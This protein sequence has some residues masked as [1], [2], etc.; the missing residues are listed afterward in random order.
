MSCLNV[1][2]IYFTRTCVTVAKHCLEV[3]SVDVLC[4]LMSSKLQLVM[5]PE[6]RG[7]SLVL[8][9]EEKPLGWPRSEME[10]GHLSGQQNWRRQRVYGG[11]D[12]VYGSFT[13]VL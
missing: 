1:I 12:R 8:K 10:K 2:L 5:E 9:P 3:S 6:D 4:L 7:Y 13:C 11:P